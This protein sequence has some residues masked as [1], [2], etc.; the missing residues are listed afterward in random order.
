[1]YTP[2]S[3]RIK[4]IDILAP[5]RDRERETEPWQL[6]AVQATIERQ[7]HR[8]LFSK[9]HK[10]APHAFCDLMTEPRWAR[11]LLHVENPRTMLVFVFTAGEEPA[12]VD[13][14]ASISTSYVLP[15]LTGWA[16]KARRSRV[17]RAVARAC[18]VA[19]AHATDRARARDRR[20][21]CS[22]SRRLSP[23]QAC[24]SPRLTSPQRK[25]RRKEKSTRFVAAQERH[26]EHAAR[27]ARSVAREGRARESRDDE[28]RSL[29]RR[30]A[31]S[32]SRVGRDCVYVT[33]RRRAHLAPRVS[34]VARTASREVARVGSGKRSSLVG[35]YL[36][37]L[38]RIPSRCAVR[39][40]LAPASRGALV[41]FIHV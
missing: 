7:A 29:A 10:W 35:I 38:T 24:S 4:Y 9:I 18:A 30:T 33:R 25:A 16:Q 37:G 8:R 22:V 12:R 20:R 15:R 23:T 3:S 39:T 19:R 36:A 17:S 41:C 13:A 40:R 32:H 31:R 34:Q 1:M 6:P 21:E 2:P 28:A 26:A 11:D 27:R 14:V 5:D